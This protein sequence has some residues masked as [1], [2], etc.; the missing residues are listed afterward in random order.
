MSARNSSLKF[1]LNHTFGRHSTCSDPARDGALRAQPQNPGQCRLTAHAL[2]SK[3]NGVFTHRMIN[4]QIVNIVN[5]KTGNGL[6]HYQ[7]VSKRAETEPSDFWRRLTE[8]W[9]AKGLPTTQ[10]GVANKLAMSQGSTHRWYTGAGYPEIP[11]LKTL[12]ELG[13]VTV[14]WLLTERLPKTPVGNETQL[15]KL[16]LLWEQLDDSGKERIHRAALGELALKP[17]SKST[18]SKKSGT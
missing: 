17:Q 7:E 10:N 18:P 1:D 13:N 15:G 11:I 2:A 3:E 12:A 5:A 9:K 16:L 4:A 6:P 14:D 8:A